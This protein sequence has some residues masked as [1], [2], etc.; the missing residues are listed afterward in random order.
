MP[1]PDNL[2]DIFCTRCGGTD[3]RR[4]A[5]AMWDARAQ[6]WVLGAVFDAGHCETCERE[7]TLGERPLDEADAR[8]VP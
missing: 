1:G 6:D 5:W 8:P 4:D 7:A 2:I 3:V